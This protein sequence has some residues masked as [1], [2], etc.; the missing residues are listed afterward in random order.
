[1]KY[2]VAIWHYSHRALFENMDYVARHGLTAI[3]LHGMQFIKA[4]RDEKAGR[5]DENRD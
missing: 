4:C 5:A 2:G 3:S 1:M